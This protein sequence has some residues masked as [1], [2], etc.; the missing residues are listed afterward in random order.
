MK[1]WIDKRVRCISDDSLVPIGAI[2]TVENDEPN[3]EDGEFTV[4]FDEPID[5]IDLSTQLIVMTQDQKDM[6]EIVESD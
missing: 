5:P 3:L 1:S 6:F 4:W 2:G